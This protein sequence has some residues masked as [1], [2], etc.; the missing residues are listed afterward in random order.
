MVGPVLLEMGGG[1]KKD[2]HLILIA[3]AACILAQLLVNGWLCYGGPIGT[4]SFCGG[5][6]RKWNALLL[7][8]LLRFHNSQIAR[9]APFRRNS[10]C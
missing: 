1:I 8:F 10:N 4:C 2:P 3:T 6:K 5:Q 7:L 9:L